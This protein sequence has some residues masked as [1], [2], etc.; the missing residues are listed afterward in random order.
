MAAFDSSIRLRQLNQPELSGYTVQIIQQYLTGV[1]PAQTGTLTGVFYPLNNNPSGYITTGQTGNF[2]TI[3]NVNSSYSQAVSYV[4]S[5]Y[6][7]NT[8][9]NNYLS[10]TSLPSPIFVFSTGIKSGVQTEFIAFPNFSYGGSLYTFTSTPK[11][12][13]TFSNSLDGNVYNVT[14]TGIATYGFYA[15]YSATIRVSGY[16]LNAIVAA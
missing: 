12:I 10:S 5:N 11:V 9:P 8:N 3:A 15:S 1:S 6:Y 16:S 14:A 7:P 13:L 2:A 4:A